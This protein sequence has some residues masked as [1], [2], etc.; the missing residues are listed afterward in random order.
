MLNIGW[1]GSGKFMGESD[2]LMKGYMSIKNF[3]ECK[4][5][6]G[7]RTEVREDLQICAG[8]DNYGTW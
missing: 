2:V 3:E 7:N 4:K 6:Y 1:G 5:L 8:H